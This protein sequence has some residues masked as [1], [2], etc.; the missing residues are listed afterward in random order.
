[1]L[2]SADEAGLNVVELTKDYF[3]KD[4]APVITRLTLPDDAQVYGMGKD[5]K[6]NIWIGG[7][8][9]SVYRFDPLKN[10]FIKLNNGKL[11]NNGYFTQDGSILI[12]NNLFLSDGKDVYPLFDINKTPAGNIIFRPREKLWIN[13]HRELYFYDVV[14]WK[15]GKPE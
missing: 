10:S 2:V 14:K 15:T 13:H 3:E 12:N 7:L 6:G 1:M 5:K 9:G 4:G 11:L 8:D